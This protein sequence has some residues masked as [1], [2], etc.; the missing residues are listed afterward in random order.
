M[1][2]KIKNILL[3]YATLPFDCLIAYPFIFMVW[4][5]WG[6]ALKWSKGGILSCELKVCSWPLGGRTDNKGHVLYRIPRWH[7]RGWFLRN[8]RAFG[9]GYERPVPW[10]VFSVGRGQIYAHRKRKLSDGIKGNTGDFFEKSRSVE[11]EIFQI[12]YVIASHVVFVFL[13]IIGG[14]YNMGFFYLGLMWILGGSVLS[15]ILTSKLFT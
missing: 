14:D 10:S 6:R 8:K 5:L 3:R 11:A 4:L 2:Y 12:M 1:A 15:L 9:D 7:F 13:G